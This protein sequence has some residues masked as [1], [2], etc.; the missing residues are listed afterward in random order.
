VH[1]AKVRPLPVAMCEVPRA[2]ASPTT[3]AMAAEH[4]FLPAALVA[5]NAF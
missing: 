2:A 1:Q 4:G 5:F 3:Q